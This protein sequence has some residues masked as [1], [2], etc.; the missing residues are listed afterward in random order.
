MNDQRLRNFGVLVIS[1][2]YAWTTEDAVV[3][4]P[5]GYPNWIKMTLTVQR[6]ERWA[7]RSMLWIRKDIEAEQLLIQS[8]DLTAAVLRLPDRSMLIVLVY[9]KGE[10][11]ATL[12]DTT[13]KLH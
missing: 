9:I 7:F 4:V 11:T 13:E 5:I 1:E 8:S 2:P 10:N 6:R 3:I 12:L